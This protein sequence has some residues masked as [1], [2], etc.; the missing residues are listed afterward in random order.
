MDKK[1]I[2]LKVETVE[3]EFLDSPAISISAWYEK[4][5]TVQP[6]IEMSDEFPE[7]G[8]LYGEDITEG[9]YFYYGDMSKE[10]IINYLKTN[11]FTI[12]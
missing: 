4:D 6:A 11:G 5:N 9:E 2:V 3:H 1:L 8:E 7:L 12:I 10:R